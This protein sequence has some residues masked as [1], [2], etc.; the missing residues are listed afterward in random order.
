MGGGKDQRNNINI[1]INN[2]SVWR[3]RGEEYSF[4]CENYATPITTRTYQSYCCCCSGKLLATAPQIRRSSEGVHWTPALCDHPFDARCCGPPDQC[5]DQWSGLNCD[6]RWVILFDW[7][8]RSDLTG[9]FEWARCDLTGPMTHH[10]YEHH[11]HSS[12]N[13]MKM[14][15]WVH[16][17]EMPIQF[18]IQNFQEERV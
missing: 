7:T 8:A 15:W 5:C 6:P 17:H 9:I 13:K 4:D 3:G 10:L 18:A 12:A 11:A 2:N 14:R 1:N 16:E